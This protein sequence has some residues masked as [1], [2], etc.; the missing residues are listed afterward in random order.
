MPSIIG[1]ANLAQ[2]SRFNR[3]YISSPR[4]LKVRRL[5]D[6]LIGS[7]PKDVSKYTPA[8]E[9]A[10]QLMNEI[11]DLLK[12]SELKDTMELIATAITSCNGD[13]KWKSDLSKELHLRLTS[14]ID[15]LMVNSKSY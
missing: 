5:M 4:Y 6:D 10:D 12:V 14:A 15:I 1:Y 9:A 13:S 7:D 3:A 2:S 11:S 8:P